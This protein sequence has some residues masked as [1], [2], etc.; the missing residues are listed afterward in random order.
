[1]TLRDLFIFVGIVAGIIIGT[2][3]QAH[4]TIIVNAGTRSPVPMPQRITAPAVRPGTGGHTGAELFRDLISRHRDGAGRAVDSPF[5]QLIRLPPGSVAAAGRAAARAMPAVAMAATAGQLLQ[6]LLAKDFTPADYIGDASGEGYQEWLKEVQ[7]EGAPAEGNFEMASNVT[8]ASGYADGHRA[9]MLSA[10][11]EGVVF[12]SLAEFIAAANVAKAGPMKPGWLNDCGAGDVVFLDAD[13]VRY[14]SYIT[15]A[16]HGPGACASNGITATANGIASCPEGGTPQAGICPNTSFVPAT[17]AALE[18]AIATATAASQSAIANEAITNGFPVEVP[19]GAP[20]EVQFLQEG[21]SL[22]SSRTQ[23]S[24]PVVT[25][26]TVYDE[27]GTPTTYETVNVQ[28]ITTTTEGSTA[29]TTTITTNVTNV[30]TTYNTTTNTIVNTT[31]QEVPLAGPGSSSGTDE[32]TDDTVVDPVTEQPRPEGDDQGEPE[33]TG[34]F[35]DSEFPE[36]PDLYEQ[37]YENGLVGVWQDK[38]GDLMGTQFITDVQSIFLDVP[39][40]GSCPAWS[41]S[42]INLGPTNFSDGDISVP[43]WLWD[44]VGLILL[45]TACFRAWSIVFG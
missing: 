33:P 43:C 29:S 12:G 28:N 23:S 36:V 16:S 24:L 2:A 25:T 22:G 5:Q 10:M 9:S 8:I 4:A 1:M 14:R 40:S 27:F 42:M 39:G 7:G 38:Q 15:Q 31:T 41:I 32:A 6:E 19:P 44:V 17:D 13:T 37:K 18:N 45:V 21:G 35:E 3:E 30:S 34:N 11:A 26:Q 20:S